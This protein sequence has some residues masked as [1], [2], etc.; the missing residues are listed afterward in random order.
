[1]I[2]SSRAVEGTLLRL[3]CQ[4]CLSEFPH[5]I[6]SGEDDLDTEYL[7]SASAADT[8]EVA[9]FQVSPQ[10]WDRTD[11]S[12]SLLIETELEKALG[13]N[14]FR[15]VRLL[16][17]EEKNDSAAGLSFQDFMKGYQPPVLV[18]SCPCCG[19]GESHSIGE[20]TIEEFEDSGGRILV[21]EGLTLVR[22]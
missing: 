1:M 4:E 13:R 15:V 7:S 11:E 5:F 21:A 9:L 16:R 17:V 6:F 10:V 14:D 12:R 19:S 3:R 18:F 20:M 8:N 22:Q 2:P